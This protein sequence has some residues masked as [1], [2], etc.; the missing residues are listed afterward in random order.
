[1]VNAVRVEAGTEWLV[2]AYGCDAS[3]L[4]SLPA[5]HAVF[6]RIVRELDL[7]PIGD[8]MWHVFPEPGGVTGLLPL[9]E[10]HLAC[11]TFPER[12]YAAFSLYCCRAR[13]EWPWAERLRELLDARDVTVRLVPRGDSLEPVVQG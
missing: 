9:S 7:H 12:G 8:A 11:H 2:D 3:T 10:S 1:V 6:A 4:R 13:D 5:M